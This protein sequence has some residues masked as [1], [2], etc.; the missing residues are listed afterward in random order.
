MMRCCAKGKRCLAVE[1]VLQTSNALSG[2]ELRKSCRVPYGVNA[3]GDAGEISMQPDLAQFRSIFFEEATDH[4]EIIQES[5]EELT[6]E[7]GAKGTS[8]VEL[9]NRIFRSIHSLKGAANSFGLDQIA[10]FAN[11]IENCLERLRDDHSQFAAGPPEIVLRSAELLQQ[12]IEAT[13]HETGP[14]GSLPSFTDELSAYATGV[15]AQSVPAPPVAE[16]PFTADVDLLT[17]FLAESDEHIERAEEV[18]LALESNPSDEENI[19]ALYRVFHTIK[20]VAAFLRL[21][22]IQ[23]LTHEAESLLDK[24][25]RG[26]MHLLDTHLDLIFRSVQALSKQLAFAAHWVDVRGPLQRDNQLPALVAEFKSAISEGNG[27]A[28]R[29]ESAAPSQAPEGESQSARPRNARQELV[30]VDRERLDQLVNVIGELVIAESMVQIE[31]ADARLS[32]RSL[33]PLGKIARE[34]QALSLSLRMVPIRSVFQKMALVARDIA[35]KVNKQVA[36]RFEGE[37]T[38]LDKS[39]VDRIGDPLIHMVRNAIDHGIELP[40]ERDSVGKQR[41]GRLDIR[42]YHKDGSICIEIQDDGRGLN[43]DAIYRKAVERGLIRE[44]DEI[45][46]S[47]VYNLVFEPGFSTAEAVTEIS[48]RGVGMDVVRRNIEPMQGTAQISSVPGQGATFTMWLPL[49]FAILDGLLVKLGSSTLVLPL[50][51]VVESLRPQQNEL[52]RFADHGEMLL[53]RGETIPLVRL[54]EVLDL[55]PSITDPA[56]GLLVVVEN[57]GARL[58]L[59]VD[60]LVGQQQVVMKSLEANYQK[61]EGVTGATILGD[62]SVALI[63]DPAALQRLALKT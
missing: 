55:P 26:E 33:P 57:R 43:R 37:D 52:R 8:H 31:F 7:A 44:G 4:L 10:V 63:V 56:Q 23:S 51:S 18:L 6:S 22:D 13:Q 25:R 61:I 58:A 47:D 41:E 54:N 5:L 24:F 2:G 48:G 53:L 28:P 59:L 20:G 11:H 29:W 1:Q 60:K 34:L 12:L 39:M 15:A 35:R 36:V 3:L 40:D 45:S 62:G 42:A 38:E 30:K 32:S 27:T 50:T 17:D 14:P 19:D 21:A 49:T 16:T 46:D 9:V